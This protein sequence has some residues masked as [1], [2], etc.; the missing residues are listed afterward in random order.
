[1][2]LWLLTRL[3]RNKYVLPQSLLT[4]FRFKTYKHDVLSFVGCE[5]Q[6][7]LSAGY[8]VS[9]LNIISFY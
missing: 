6:M 2:F 3:T 9:L 7:P 1:M 4:V 8:S 5:Q